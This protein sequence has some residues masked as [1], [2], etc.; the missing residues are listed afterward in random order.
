[1]YLEENFSQ[2]STDIVAK[3]PQD[4]EDAS[5]TV[6]VL[7]ISE[8]ATMLAKYWEEFLDMVHNNVECLI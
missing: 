8:E 1:M 2:R 5:E 4:S 3:F 7:Q 6:S